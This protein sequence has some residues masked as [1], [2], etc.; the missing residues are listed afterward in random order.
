[1]EKE[2]EF[3]KFDDPF[4]NPFNPVKQPAFYE[5]RQFEIDLYLDYCIS[6][7]DPVPVVR[8]DEED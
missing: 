2:E 7:Y 6:Q 3:D 4:Y 1:M 8:E 5:R